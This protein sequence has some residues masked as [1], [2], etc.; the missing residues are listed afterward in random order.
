MM[1]E[2]IELDSS[3]DEH[4]SGD[5]QRTE[6]NMKRRRQTTP[7][8]SLGETTIDLSSD[9]SSS[10]AHVRQHSQS[11]S[12]RPINEEDSSLDDSVEIIEVLEVASS[13]STAPSSSGQNPS[14]LARAA[15]RRRGTGSLRTDGG[16][17]SGSNGMMLGRRLLSELRTMLVHAGSEGDRRRRASHS[18]F[19]QALPFQRQFNTDSQ[20][21][22]RLAEMHA[23]NGSLHDGD[24]RKRKRARHAAAGQKTASKR[25]QIGASGSQ[26][27]EG[28]VECPIC[29]DVISDMSS[30]KCGHVFCKGCIESQIKTNKK[31]PI[32]TKKLGLRDIHP[33]FL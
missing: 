9:S 21:S 6:L 12:A 8:E 2:I 19:S 25:H 10:E 29:L 7:V 4:P 14:S 5:L 23:C 3:E 20:G 16:P 30:T 31:C 18:N 24:S 22:T 1:N 13:P 15:P 27:K 26:K 32:C 28:G 33:I 17:E 11:T